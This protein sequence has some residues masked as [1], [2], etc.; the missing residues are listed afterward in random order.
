MTPIGFKIW[1]TDGSTFTSR[2]GRWNA[3][4]VADVAV[5]TIY[6]QETYRQ[7]IQDGWSESGVPQNQ[8]QVTKNYCEQLHTGDFYWLTMSGN[9]I[10]TWGNGQAGQVPAGLPT[11]ALKTGSLM[12]KE[13]WMALY[14]GAKEERVSP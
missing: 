13:D 8:R 2:Q 12:L 1:Y 10:A 11:N 4:P 3:A 5:V 14:N 9:T 6:F 7:W